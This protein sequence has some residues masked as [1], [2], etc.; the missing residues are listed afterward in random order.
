MTIKIRNKIIIA[1][2]FFSLLLILAAAFV[3][4]KSLIQ[5]TFAYPSAAL[6]PYN[7]MQKPL[8]IRFSFAAVAA[9]VFMFMIYVF[10][11]LLYIAIEFEKTQ[12]TELIYFSVF[13][14]A[15]SM[16][17]V[18]LAFPLMNLWTRAALPALVL[19]RTVL[20]GRLLAPLA[21]LFA[22]IFNGSENRQYIGQN[23]IVLTVITLS[24]AVFAP[25]NTTVVL[26]ECRLQ[27]GF[28][29]LFR[30]VQYLIG[31]LAIIAYLIQSIASGAPGK[32]P[33]SLLLLIGG[34]LALCSASNYLL[35]VFGSAALI[36]GTFIYLKNLH[37]KYLWGT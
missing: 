22:T 14:I 6:L 23:I 20:Q 36:S 16:E 18:R 17:S 30:T 32:F 26:A 1:I 29:A 5:K 11:S 27:T 8:L 37:T 4:G 24:L 13:L 34:Y 3:T 12:S 28:A 21:I 10:I 25:L 7:R 15:C 19:S 33:L 31:A 9:S 2:M 35:L